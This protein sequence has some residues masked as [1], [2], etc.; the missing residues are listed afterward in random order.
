MKRI[1]LV[2]TL[3]TVAY[4]GVFVLN[5]PRDYVGLGDAVCLNQS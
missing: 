5:Q 1:F 4:A 3:L 2:L